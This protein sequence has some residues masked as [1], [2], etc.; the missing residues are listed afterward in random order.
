[1]TILNKTVQMSLLHIF[2]IYI[3]EVNKLNKQ[4]SGSSVEL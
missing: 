2:K 4:T 1:M 3:T